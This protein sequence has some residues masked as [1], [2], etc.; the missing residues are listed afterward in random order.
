VH[1]RELL[2]QKE[3]DL[4]IVMAIGD[5]LLRSRGDHLDAPEIARD[6][7]LHLRGEALPERVDELVE[8]R[9]ERERGGLVFGRLV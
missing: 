5:P 2:R 6:E 4:L 8:L 7:G 3:E 9:E 1:R